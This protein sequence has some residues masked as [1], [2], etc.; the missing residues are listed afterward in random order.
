MKKNYSII[1]FFFLL[2]SYAQSKKI[3]YVDEKFNKINFSDYSKK[4]RTKLFDIAI[5]YND[6]STFKKLRYKEFFG[7]INP[8]VKKTINLIY[9]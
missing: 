3:I 1:I 6:T 7:T 2:T 9:L 8:R 5:F 4:L